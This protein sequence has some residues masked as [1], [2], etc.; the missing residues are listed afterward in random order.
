[1]STLYHPQMDGQ[2]ECANCNIR[3]IFCT[4]ICNDQKDWVDQVNLTEF[5]INASV[6]GTT[7]YALFE[8]NSG[9]M[10]SI[11]CEICLYNVSP[12]G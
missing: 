10:P 6:F 1:M 4:I 7:K 8:L 12:R 5:A 2:T 9:Y 3:Q 11:I